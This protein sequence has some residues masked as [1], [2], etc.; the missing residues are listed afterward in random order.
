M[1]GEAE[2][3]Q[4]ATTE[5]IVSEETTS[6]ATITTEGQETPPAA[7]DAE[8]EKT[9][10]QERRERRKAHEQKLREDADKARHEA[11]TL[12]QK[13]AR[14]EAA[15]GEAPK[16]G[17][18]SDPIE[19]AA[20]KGAYLARTDAARTDATLLEQD[21]KAHDDA[22]SSAND[23]RR[24]AMIEAYQEQVVEAK[25]RYADFDQVVA[26]ASNPSIVSPDLSLMII[27]SDKAADIA[28]HLGKNPALAL[29]LSQMPPLSAARELGR[30]EATLS[31][32]SPKTTTAAPSPI[33][34]VRPS[35][36]ASRDPDK[37][38]M[39]EFMAARRSGQLK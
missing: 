10:S 26:V 16:E 19:Y 24:A 31:L 27:E 18:F 15:K 13:I 4:A 6:D 34:P 11:D 12:R 14:I 7:V 5:A 38:T 1:T 3:A 33:T 39:E 2:V 28:Y 21:A 22:A 35:A 30:I 8:K 9:A 29:Q 17:D 36:T 23:W 25:T 20:A 37:M 32:P